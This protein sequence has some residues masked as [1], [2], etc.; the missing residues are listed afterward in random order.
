MLKNVADLVVSILTNLKDSRDLRRFDCKCLEDIGL[1]PKD[2]ERANGWHHCSH[3]H[4]P[5]WD[6][7]TRYCGRHEF[8]SPP[9]PFS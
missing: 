4:H 1:A 9:S 2:F 5:S 3:A 7:D 6:D 8:S